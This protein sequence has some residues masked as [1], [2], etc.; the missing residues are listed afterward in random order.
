MKTLLLS[1]AAVLGFAAAAP[2]AV[3][4]RSSDIGV[5]ILPEQTRSSVREVVRAALR[6]FLTFRKETPLSDEQRTAIRQILEDHRGELQTQ[7][8]HGREARRA[9][10]AA[11]KENAGSPAAKAAAE[12]VGEVARDRALLGARISAEVRPLLTAEQQKRVEAA[13]SEIEGLVDEALA[14]ALR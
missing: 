10:A 13:R 11:A 4:G 1:L 7:M 8:A 14:S 9:M 12:K 6:N 5:G 2:A 3:L